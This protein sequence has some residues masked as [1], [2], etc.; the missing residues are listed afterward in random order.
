MLGK[1]FFEG[2]CVLRN[3][4]WTN[5]SLVLVLI[6]SLFSPFASLKA[7]AAAVLQI[8]DVT[9]K[10]ESTVLVWEVANDQGEELTNYQLIKND[11]VLDIEPVLLSESA[12]DNVRRYSY[13]DENVEKNT[14]YKYE[15]AATLS[16]GEKVVSAPIEHTFAQQE[17]IQ[18]NVVEVPEGEAVTAKIKVTTDQGN[19]PWDFD[20][21]IEDEKG[22]EVSL[23]GF[24]DEEGYFVYSDTDSRDIELPV[25]TYTLVTYNYSTEEEITAEF[26]LESGLDYVTNP[27]ELVLPDEKLIL[28]KVLKLEAITDQSISMG[29]D[30][31]FEYDEV[32]KYLVYLNDQLVEEITDPYT[33]TYTYSGLVPDTQYQVK[34][35]YI[36]KDGTSESAS[37]D[38]TT[39]PSPVGEVVDFA[40]E[41]L[42][43]AIKNQLKINHRDIYTDDMETLKYLD[44]S[45]SDIT[46]LTGL[47]F[48]V[49]LV[50][51][52]LYGNQIEDL[53]PLA[54][55]TNLVSLDLDENMISSL[56]DLSQLH[57]LESLFLSFNQIEDITVL[58]ELHN[59]TYVMLNGNEGL[60]FT[61]GSEDAEVL[62]SLIS[63]GVS[64]E[65]MLDTSEISIKEV[66]E[67][68]IEFEFRFPGVSD[69]IS[70][71]NVSLNGELVAEIPVEENS[72]AL[73][74]LEPLT[75]YEITVDAVDRDGNVW[76]SAYSYVKTPPVPEG[77]VIQ[78]KD[79]AL[80]EAVRDALHIYSRDL[81]KSDMTILTNLD[82]SDRG[83]EN[84]DGLEYAVN[85]EEL[86]LDYNSV[87][88]LEPIAGLTNLLYLSV[89]Y[90]NLSDISS[91]ATLTNLGALMLDGNE[92]SDISIL[93]SFSELSMLSLQGNKIK[94]IQSLAG[95]NIEYL[96]IGYNEIED[97]SSLLDLENLRYVL[98]M[99]NPLDLTEGS[100]TLSMIQTL[101][102]NGVIVNYE[103]LDITVHNVTEN[104]MEIRWQP[105][106]TDGYEDYL[107]YVMLD[108][109]EVES[110]LDDTSYTF[111]DLQRDTPYMI[112][113]IGISGDYERVIYGTT[114]VTTTG[115]KEEPTDGA[116]PGED[117]VGED[118]TPADQGTTPGK[119]TGKSTTP[120]AKTVE[121]P[122]NLPNTATNSFNLLLIGFGF[123]VVGVT[124]LVIK[125]RKVVNH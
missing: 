33:T 97:I 50:D 2:G 11:E 47:E 113:I 52:M 32:E 93:S 83:I 18:T 123:V 30:E 95:L 19:I 125:R 87:R 17:E 3:R 100:E 114:L 1:L 73:T 85:L 77:E 24:L 94:D 112:E 101:E 58:K 67:S 20:F 104:S 22:S 110:D 99:K 29:W 76:G 91:L 121:K 69:F 119:E 26:T 118:K 57:N 34:V 111:T 88:N 39:S 9:E 98:I 78:F 23:Y 54:N 70:T 55:L 103:Y 105:V 27:V 6:F 74:D 37:A 106:T 64:V 61:K 102:D 13:E 4:K 7:Y 42:E 75:D 46:D 38:V 12:E 28:K 48:A 107:Y 81:F 71:Y 45:Y 109:E 124:F 41:N 79:Q 68:S 51:L 72:Y 15:I 65:W 62:K 14:V 80:Q 43:N 117:P 96:N 66:T 40:D 49:N 90:N 10:S 44:A 53:S 115:E 63:A 82:A 84:L 5:L 25:G 8:L 86:Q 122:G 56:D 31:P 92:I 120:D 16:T 59:L 36:Y 89:T 60:D 116:K 35:E 108:G 21:Y